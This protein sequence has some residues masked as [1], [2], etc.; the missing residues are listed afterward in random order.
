MDQTIAQIPNQ[1]QAQ[2]PAQ[3]QNPPVANSPKPQK[4]TAKTSKPL[5]ISLVICAI[6][7]VAGIAFGI[8]GLI[9]ANHESSMVSDL[10]DIIADKDQTIA[11]LKNPD[12]P[13]EPTPDTPADTP[14]T[15]EPQTNSYSLFVNNLAKTYSPRIFGHYYHYTGTDNI[16]R[17]V[18]AGVNQNGH[19]TITDLD[20]NDKL[21]A[22]AD[23]VANIYYVQIGNGGVPYFY[24]FHK[25]GKVSRISLLNI[26]DPTIEP[27]N[28][29]KDIVSVLKGSDLFAYLI[30][31]NGNVYKTY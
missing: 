24:L 30:D 14:T 16:E 26:D 22:E 28:D 3:P 21:I 9:T 25:D 4:S 1:N 10:K 13:T 8:F 29:Y 7:A 12:S 20:D 17:T 23:G 5:V 2:A 15:S 19:L 31:I 27:L 11:N 18:L 6:L